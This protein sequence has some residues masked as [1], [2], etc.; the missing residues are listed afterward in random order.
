M[1]KISFCL[2]L[3]NFYQNPDPYPDPHSSKMMD[4]DKS[5]MM[6]PDPYP[7]PHIPDNQCGSETL[8]L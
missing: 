4:P 5:K 7:D 2:T 8:I 3:E 1:K 6:D